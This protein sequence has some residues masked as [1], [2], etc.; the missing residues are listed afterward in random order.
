MVLVIQQKE[1]SIVGCSLIDFNIDVLVR[2]D[3]L[4]N[5]CLNEPFFYTLVFSLH[6]DLKEHSNE[7]F[8]LVVETLEL[9]F[10]AKILKGFD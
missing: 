2:L 3:G 7:Y 9:N 5:R 10:K 8:K 4:F 1:E 6:H